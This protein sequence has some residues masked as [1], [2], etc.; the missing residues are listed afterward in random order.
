M[1]MGISRRKFLNIS[2]K[3]G[4]YGLVV[5]LFGCVCNAFARENNKPEIIKAHKEWIKEL[6]TN[7]DDYLFNL[8]AT[9]IPNIY[10]VHYYPTSDLKYFRKLTDNRYYNDDVIRLK[11]KKEYPIIYVSKRKKR[12][13][14]FYYFPYYSPYNHP[15]EIQRIYKE[16]KNACSKLVGV[17]DIRDVKVEPEDNPLKYV[18]N[19][20]PVPDDYFRR[21]MKKIEYYRDFIGQYKIPIGLIF[22]KSEVGCDGIRM[23]IYGPSYLR[24]DV[25]IVFGHKDPEECLCVG[26]AKLIPIED[27]EFIKNDKEVSKIPRKEHYKSY[28]TKVT[29]LDVFLSNEGNSTI[30]K[31]NEL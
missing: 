16:F 8:C 23:D 1:V 11:D 7:W 12:K 5:S 19:G 30:L 20:K 31:L 28:I 18:W 13:N 15:E 27:N 6:G 17:N 9:M 24:K 14:L 4:A 21:H 3:V 26:F 2:A 25:V 22:A 29:G 10:G